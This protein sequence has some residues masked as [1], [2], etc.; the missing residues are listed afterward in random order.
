[1]DE[2]TIRSRIFKA[3]KKRQDAQALALLHAR[4]L[5]R[6]SSHRDAYQA[7]LKARREALG[8]SQ[9]ALQWSTGVRWQTISAYEA[10]RQSL[11][12]ERAWVLA[13]ALQVSVEWLLTG[14]RL[15]FQDPEPAAP[16]P[17]ET[18]TYSPP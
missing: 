7:R 11:S 13:R 3:E 15:R 14:K 12:L 4:L 9:Q 2:K 16:I 1:M 8:L 17:P 10:G 6:E 18:L 5:A